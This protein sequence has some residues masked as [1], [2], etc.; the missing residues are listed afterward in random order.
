MKVKKLPV[1]VHVAGV[2]AMTALLTTLTQVGGVVFLLSIVIGRLFSLEKGWANTLVF[3]GL[4]LVTSV[5]IAPPLAKLFGRV[6]IEQT[7]GVKPLRWATVAMNRHYVVPDWNV[8]LAKMEDELKGSEICILY[9]DANFPFPGIPLAPHL[10]HKDGKKL[11]LAFVYA[12]ES[13]SIVP[14]G[15]S[16]TGY[17]VFSGPENGETDQPSICA[18]REKGRFYELASWL[19]FGSFNDELTFDVRANRKL[20]K[21]FLQQ[22][23]AEKM[24]V[25]PHL[26]D[27]MNLGSYSKVRWQGCHSVRHDDHFHMQI[28]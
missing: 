10:S 1:W 14:A 24:F 25:E 17:G 23:E 12:D 9:L 15:K 4:Y 2:L 3:L 20:A 19:S 5:F 22:R 6:P 27:R 18:K 11:D 7:E 8:V 28:R 21:A 16:T 26:K 13:G